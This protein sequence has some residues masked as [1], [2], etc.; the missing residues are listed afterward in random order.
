M[1]VSAA[2]AGQAALAAA[3]ALGGIVAQSMFL[4]LADLSYRKGTVQRGAVSQKSTAQL[5]LVVALLALVIMALGSP[6]AT[7]GVHYT[8]PLLIGGYLGGVFMIRRIPG[9]EDH[10][11]IHEASTGDAPAQV[12]PSQRGDTGGSSLRGLYAALGSQHLLLVGVALLFNAVLL[13]GF[14]RRGR[15]IGGRIAPE[16][17]LVLVGYVVTAAVLVFR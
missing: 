13:I 8:T 16:S 6:T 9:E 2:L 10:K 15:G 4:A 1:T 17:V 14:I 11:K 7:L 3:N 5:G 12:A